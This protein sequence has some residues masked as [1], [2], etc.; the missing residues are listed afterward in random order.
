MHG[1]KKQGGSLP[2]LESISKPLLPFAA[3]AVGGELLKVL[4]SRIFG[5][6]KRSLKR[7][8]LLQRPPAPKRVQLPNGRVFFGK[9][10]RVGRERPRVRIRRTYV[11]KIGPRRKELEGK[12]Q[13]TNVEKDNKLVE[14]LIY[15]RP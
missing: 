2:I 4:G 1:G 12:V 13:E 15:P 9:C 8:I 14:A 11:K 10:Q 6:G 3:S 5:K 7:R